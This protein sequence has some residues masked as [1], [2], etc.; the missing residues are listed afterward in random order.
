MSSK[1]DFLSATVSACE[2]G[3]FLVGVSVS[4]KEL[5]AQAVHDEL[6]RWSASHMPFGA[7]AEVSERYIKMGLKSVREKFRTNP[8]LHQA[9]GVFDPI[10]ILSVISALFSIIGWLRKWFSGEA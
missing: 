4:Q 2:N 7:G 3:G 10:T 5:A 9:Y 6:H 1:S 8:E